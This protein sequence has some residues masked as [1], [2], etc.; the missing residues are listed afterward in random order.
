MRRSPLSTNPALRRF[1]ARQVRQ[2]RAKLRDHALSMARDNVA[3]LLSHEALQT[4]I[5]LSDY[6]AFADLH[7]I[8]R[9]YAS[10]LGQ[11]PNP[12]PHF[13]SRPMFHDDQMTQRKVAGV[14]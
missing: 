7:R 3:L 5:E 11:L 6:P 9:Q 14:R 12:Q 8:A 2:V 10:Y 1:L 4:E 13:S